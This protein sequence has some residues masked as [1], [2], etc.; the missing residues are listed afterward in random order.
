LSPK[1]AR[2][3]SLACDSYDALIGSYEALL[4]LQAQQLDLQA[5]PPA[6]SAPADL[7]PGRQVQLLCFCTQLHTRGLPSSSLLVSDFDALHRRR[8]HGYSRLHDMYCWHSK[9]RW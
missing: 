2:T 3:V 1:F 9:C 5:Q 6:L 4:G 7:T 8:R